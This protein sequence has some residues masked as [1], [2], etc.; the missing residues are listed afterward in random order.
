MRKMND[1]DDDKGDS[2]NNHLK[3]VWLLILV[4]W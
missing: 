4:G 1:E 3:Y 2:S